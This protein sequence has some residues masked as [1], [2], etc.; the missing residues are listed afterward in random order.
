MKILVAPD[1]FKGTLGAP[2]AAS[3]IARGIR[4]VLPEAAIVELPLADGGEGTADVLGDAISGR[5]S[6]IEVAATSGRDERGDALSAS[7]VLTGEALLETLARPGLQLAYVAVGGSRSTDG[8]TGMATAAGWRFLDKHGQALPPGGGALPD[9]HRIGGRSSSSAPIVALCDV[10]N[11]LLGPDGAA[12]VFAPQKGATPEQVELLERGLERLAEVVQRDL[13]VDIGTPEGSGAGGGIAGGLLAFFGASLVDGFAFV[14]ED[15]G[16]QRV[17]EEADV[18]IT[19]EGRLDGGSLR[20]KV[21]TGV[22]RMAHSAGKKCY[23]VCGDVRLPQKAWRALG[24]D[25][26]IAVVSIS[27]TSRAFARPSEALGETAAR[28]MLGL[29]L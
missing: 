23:A 17:I 7:S 16:L 2:A 4:S 8:G 25:G 18:V 6:L 29:A 12:R 22:A 26:A 9:L 13:G 27:G 21:T 24:F 1:K 5:E 15:V 14:A 28:L 3:A 20:G 10:G 19:G 11:P